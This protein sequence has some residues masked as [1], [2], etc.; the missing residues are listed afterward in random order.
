MWEYFAAKSPTWRI[1]PAFADSMQASAIKL[2]VTVEL[3]VTLHSSFSEMETT[4][5]GRRFFLKWRAGAIAKF[6]HDMGVGVFFL[7]FKMRLRSCLYVCVRACVGLHLP[8]R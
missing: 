7:S 1:F 3:L 2:T 6:V 4:W 5:W 8:Q